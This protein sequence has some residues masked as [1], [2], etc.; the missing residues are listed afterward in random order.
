MMR[1]A[2]AGRISQLHGWIY[3]RHLNILG[4]PTK[5]MRAVW[6]LYELRIRE[7]WLVVSKAMHAVATATKEWI[8]AV[9]RADHA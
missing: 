1:S 4:W 9:E 8:E 7:Q 3:Y 5:R 2:L 6:W